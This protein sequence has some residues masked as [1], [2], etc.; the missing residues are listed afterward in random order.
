MQKASCKREQKLEPGCSALAG[1]G[2]QQFL[3]TFGKKKKHTQKR[4]ERRKA[5]LKKSSE[6]MKSASALR[7]AHPDSETSR[8]SELDSV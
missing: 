3:K 4:M 6:P 1:F 5:G 7:L 2:L 8:K